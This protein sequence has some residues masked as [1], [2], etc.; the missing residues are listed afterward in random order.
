MPILENLQGVLN[1]N[2]LIKIPQFQHSKRGGG[3]NINDLQ[4][5]NSQQTSTQ[6]SD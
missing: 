3:G 6:N 2:V 1:K 4:L 5:M